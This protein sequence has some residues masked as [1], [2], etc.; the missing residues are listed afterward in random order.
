MNNQQKTLLCINTGLSNSKRFIFQRLNKL[1]INLVVANAEKNW[2]EPYVDDWIITDTTN[3]STALKAI[4]T[5]LRAHSI[6]GVLTFWEDDVLLTSKIVD[7]YGL[8][9]IPYDSALK[10]R[11][12]FEFRKFCAHHG[13][14][15]PKFERVTSKKDLSA[16]MSTF[17]FPVVVKPVFGSS[18]AYVIKADSPQELEDIFGFVKS[19]LSDKVESA[20]T[21]GLEILVEEYIDGDEVDIDMLVQNGKV[22]FKSISDN[23]ATQEPFFLENGQATPSSLPQKAQQELF[24][25]AEYALERLGIMHGCIHFEAKHTSTGPVPIEINV[26]LGGDESYP[27]NKVVWKVDLIESAVKIALGEYIQKVD[28]SI[29]PKKYVISK[30]FIAD[31]SGILTRLHIPPKFPEALCVLEKHFYKEIGDSA[32]APPSDYEFLG[33]I[34]CAG[35]NINDARQN[36]EEAVGLIDYEVVPFS[37][38]STLGKTERKSQFRTAAIQPRIIQGKAR[39]ERIRHLRKRDQRNLVIGIACNNYSSTQGVVESDLTVIGKNIEETLQ[40]RGYHTLFIDF[41]DLDHAIEVLKTGKVD[42]VFNVGERLNNSSLLEPHIA[43]LLDAYQIPY[44]GSNPFTLGLCIDKIKVKKLL[45]Y[46]KIPTA[47]WDYAYDV[48][49]EINAELRYPL[50]VK[51]ANTDNSIGIT[52]DSV[53]TDKNML[54]KQIE[55]VIQTMNRP[56]LVEEYLDSDEY[57]VSIIGSEDDDI[58]VLPLSRI[59][60]DAL[61]AGFWHISPFESKFLE[62]EMYK[63]KLVVERPPKNV[64]KKL[65]TLITEIALDTYNILDCHD[66]G[67]VEIKLDR[68][69]NPHVLELNPNPSIHEAGCVASVAKL[70]GYDYGD[71]LEEIIA[72]AIKRYKDRPPY[73]HLQ[74]SLL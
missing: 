15:F 55:Y 59:I 42:F 12:K 27:F 31:K 41:N 73:Y 29:E 43:A 22:K 19:N 53:V 9:G 1:P 13:I 2:A 70:V 60:Y 64:N 65:L 56:V 66:Y 57:D 7:A 61:P 32:L 38:L 68:S 34:A 74:P 37:P 39:I 36:L 69:G 54:Q 67:R 47:R 26:R 46:H 62:G 50:I 44:T 33:W 24:E 16:V 48:H 30:T 10:V 20:L 3:H 6:D 72:L 17:A 5:Y 18:S 14:R 23:F 28:Q 25:M 58:K 21:D 45:N 71:F 51:P 11:N 40:A 4:E 49:D 35:D 8:R 52:N 63:A